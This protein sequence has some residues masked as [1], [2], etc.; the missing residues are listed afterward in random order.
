MGLFYVVPVLNIKNISTTHSLV[1]SVTWLFGRIFPEYYRYR[2]IFSDI[3]WYSIL[4]IY[5]YY[6]EYNFIVV[7]IYWYFSCP[8]AGDG[9]WLRFL[10][11]DGIGWAAPCL[12]TV[13]GTIFIKI[14]MYMIYLHPIFNSLTM[15]IYFY[16]LELLTTVM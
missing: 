10:I 11:G 4:L 14:V 1:V 3:Y 5:Y 8:G 2:L 6:Y 9:W 16:S 7:Y 13:L 15:F 12:S